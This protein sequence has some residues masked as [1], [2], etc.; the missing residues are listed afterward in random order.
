[1]ENKI[2]IFD[3][4]NTIVDSLDYWYDVM[5][6]QTFTHFGLTPNEKIKELRVGKSNNE[7]AD[8]FIELSGLKIARSQVL[9]FWENSMKENYA[10][11]IKFIDGAKEYLYKLK[12]QNAKLILASA[13]E[14]NLLKFAL[15]HFDLEIFDEV[16]TESSIGYA[17]HNQMFF[18]K[19]LENLN[20]KP[21]DVILFEDSFVALKSATSVGIECVAVLSKYNKKHLMEL[22]SM[23]KKVI[24]DYNKFNLGDQQ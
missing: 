8:T 6:K 10:N 7:I 11:K 18:K 23:C 14:E 17:K 2:Y 1:M 12:K 22:Q 4:D 3:F 15:K 16:Y 20:A 21:E 19:C 13:T 5:D 24:K 9:N